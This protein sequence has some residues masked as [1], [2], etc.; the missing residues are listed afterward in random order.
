MN[1]GIL[2]GGQLGRMLALAAHPL[3]IGVTVVDPNPSTPALAVART[4]VTA[5][6]DPAGLAELA[7]ECDV[8]TFEF[9]NVPDGAVRELAKVRPVYPSADV[10]RVS[11]DR[12]FEKTAFVELGMKTPGFVRVDEQRDVDAAFAELGPLVLKTRRF[13]YDGKG[14]KVV[15]SIDDCT[16]AFAELGGVP[17]IAEAF[18]RFERELSVLVCRGTSGETV[19]YPL[20]ENHHEGGI[21]RSSLCPAPNV[22]EATKAT[23]EAWATALVSHFEYVGVLALE[24]FDLGDGLLV[25]ECAPRVHNSGHLTIEG[26]RTSQFENH[27]RAVCG[28][29]LGSP[30][31]RSPTAMLNCI[32][33]MPTPA[34]VLAIPDAHLHDYGKPPRPGRKVGHVTVCAENYEVLAERVGRL[35]PFLRNE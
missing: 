3:G 20:V 5:Y 26:A 11:Q 34:D 8:V 33:A 23:A 7:K 35:T 27:V 30:E 24:L 10:L 32:G 21:L 15:R 13:G 25:N 12:L 18:V 17:L 14:Q 28:L 22:S 1:L 31:M 4:I 19:V 29:P 6:D 2:G 16:G 9:E